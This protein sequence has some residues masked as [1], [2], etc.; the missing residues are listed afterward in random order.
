MSQQH[1]IVLCTE[2]NQHTLMAYKKELVP[3]TSNV[4]EQVLQ[5]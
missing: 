3:R 5:I 4:S 1:L 2:K